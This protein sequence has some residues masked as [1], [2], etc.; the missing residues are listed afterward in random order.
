ML[1]T[2]RLKYRPCLRLFDLSMSPTMNSSTS[3]YFLFTLLCQ[4]TTN[5]V[6]MEVDERNKERCLK[7][8]RLVRWAKGENLS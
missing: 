6:F 4:V 2:L 8:R 5:L 7:R 3:F 1:Y